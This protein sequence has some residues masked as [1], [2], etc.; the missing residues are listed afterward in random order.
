MHN[1]EAAG[2]MF[3]QSTANN[4]E[5]VANL[6]FLRVFRPT[7]PKPSV[8]WEMSNSLRDGMHDKGFWFT[9]VTA[10]SLAAK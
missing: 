2:S 9:G 1:C 5:Q 6:S 3:I 7:Q 8:G 10:C 4:P